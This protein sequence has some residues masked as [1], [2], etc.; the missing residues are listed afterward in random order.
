VGDLTI[1]GDQNR[2]L[3]TKILASRCVNKS[4]DWGGQSSSLR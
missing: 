2:F 1:H 4:S 3:H